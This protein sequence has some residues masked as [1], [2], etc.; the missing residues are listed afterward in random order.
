MTTHASHADATG[1]SSVQKCFVTGATG[2]PNSSR[3]AATSVLTGLTEAIHCS[4]L[5][6][7]AMGTKALLRNVSGNT[8][9]KATPI[10][11]SGER[12]SI[13]IHV[14]T[15]II[16]EANRSSSSSPSVISSTPVWALQP[17]T[18]PV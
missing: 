2:L 18:K 12:T 4:T 9:T 6:I 3:T 1:W 15:Q 13:P 8:A 7:D 16:A 17:T 14:S 10:T 11:A 5:G